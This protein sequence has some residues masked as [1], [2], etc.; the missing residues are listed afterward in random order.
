MMKK[1]TGLRSKVAEIFAVL[2]A[3]VTLLVTIPQATTM[4]L[5]IPR[6]AMKYEITLKSI[7]DA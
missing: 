6:A 4:K 3:K 7:C 2:K 5:E 1:A